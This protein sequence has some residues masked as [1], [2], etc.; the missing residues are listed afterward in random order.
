MRVLQFLESCDEILGLDSLLLAELHDV[1]SHFVQVVKC[2]KK[3][4]SKVN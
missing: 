2:L 3:N 4:R 1:R